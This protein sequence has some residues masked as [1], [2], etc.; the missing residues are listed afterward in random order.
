MRFGAGS[1]RT[2]E[3][4]VVVIATESL[5]EGPALEQL[6]HVAGL[7]GVVL[8]VGLPDLHAGASCPIGA[9]IATN[10]M[11]YPSLVGSDI[12]C[13][14]LLAETSLTSSS[15]CKPRTLDRWAERI[16]LEDPWDGDYS[17]MLAPAGLLI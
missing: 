2:A 5:V 17:G 3:T 12:G 13:G 11:L 7:P 16:Q 14:I 1:K 9:A 4:K 8:A 6:N 10:R 15:A